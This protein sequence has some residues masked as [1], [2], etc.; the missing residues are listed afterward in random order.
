VRAVISLHGASLLCVLIIGASA[1]VTAG[2]MQSSR[3]REA[4]YGQS[5]GIHL[6]RTRHPVPG[7]PRDGH[8]LSEQEEAA[9]AEIESA[10]KSRT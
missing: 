3:E 7:L 5:R 8:K 9:L 1:A 2:M 6:R 4:R 10:A